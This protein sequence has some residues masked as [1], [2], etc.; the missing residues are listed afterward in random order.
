[1]VLMVGLRFYGFASSYKKNQNLDLKKV[2]SRLDKILPVFKTAYSVPGMVVGVLLDN[3][4]IYRKS[5]GLRRLG[6]NRK[7]TTRSLFHM[8][9]VSKPFVATAIMQLVE[10]GKMKLDANLIN[11]LPYF[12]LADKKYKDITI[13]QILNH[14]SGIPDVTDYE[15]DKPQFDDG[16]AERYVRSLSEKKML[17]VPGKGYRYSNMAYDILAAVIARISGKTFETYVKENVFD[18]LDMKDSTFL[19][20]EV[21]DELENNAHIVDY[22]SISL[23]TKVS[24]EYPY[25]RIHAPSSTLHSNVEDMMRWGMANLNSGVLDGEKIL[26]A[27]THATMWK[28]PLNEQSDKYVGMSWF[29]DKYKGLTTVSHGG[30]D[31]G[32]RTYFLMVPKMNLAIVTMGNCSSFNS[33]AVVNSVLDILLGETPQS[34]KQPVTVPVGL[35][36]LKD[37]IKSALKL[38]KSLKKLESDNYIFREN[39]LNNLG[40]ALIKEKRLDDAIEIFKLNVHEY[41]DSWNV[42]DSLGDA[43][44]L[45]GEFKKSLMNFKK[46]FKKNLRKNDHDKRYAKYQKKIIS[47]LETKIKTR[48]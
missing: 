13:R 35:K 12:K 44:K 43:F 30:G 24:D 3:T 23:K 20:R 25:N 36:I 28:P 38:Y 21:P 46:A 31:L 33:R 26:K 1:M 19:K 22:N 5:L 11:Y 32:F 15:W 48:L 39:L 47:E 10:K 18:P 6:S 27:T 16:A 29:V 4:V 34:P 45:N 42:Y 41:P 7:V 8:A 17:F 14:T 2:C 40:Y 9:S 37:G